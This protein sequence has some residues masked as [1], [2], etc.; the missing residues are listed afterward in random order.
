MKTDDRP[1]PWLVRFK[2]SPRA[3]LRLFCFPYAGGS[4]HIFSQWPQFLPDFIEVCA[5]QPPGRGSR[6]REEPFQR[7]DALVVA[8]TSALGPF[9]NMPFAFFGHSMGGTIGFEVARRLRRLGMD[10]P[11]HLF[12]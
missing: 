7:L 1:T 10:G 12:V 4:A 8:A 5:V 2:A 6:L 9:M 11:A 3:R